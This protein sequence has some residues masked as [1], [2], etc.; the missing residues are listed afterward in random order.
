MIKDPK[1]WKEFE[2]SLTK[3]EKP[4]YKRN[5]KI[6]EEL[7]KHAKSMKV[8]PPKNPLEGIEADIRIAKFLNSVK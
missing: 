8:F 1:S 5:L 3:R 4:D 6:F 2:T 7:V